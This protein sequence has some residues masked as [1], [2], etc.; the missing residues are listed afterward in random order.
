VQINDIS[1]SDI[2]GAARTVD[3]ETPQRPA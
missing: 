2:P 3:D 1:M